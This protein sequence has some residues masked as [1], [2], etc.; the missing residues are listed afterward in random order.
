MS[1][2][3]HRS[4]FAELTLSVKVTEVGSFSV[5]IYN[6]LEIAYACVYTFGTVRRSDQ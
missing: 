6:I 3:L 2:W 1:G 4:H 5:P